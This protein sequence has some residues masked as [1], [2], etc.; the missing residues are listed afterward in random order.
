MWQEAGHSTLH[1][2]PRISSIMIPV[3]AD[4][5]SHSFRKDLT[6][7]TLQPRQVVFH[8]FRSVLHA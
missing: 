5:Q 1:V 2:Q 3:L 7:Q 6:A 4:Q 8:V